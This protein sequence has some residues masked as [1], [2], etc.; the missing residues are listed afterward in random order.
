MKR[1]QRV[2][3]EIDRRPWGT[4]KRIAF[5]KHIMPTRVS[6]VLLVREVNEEYLSMIEQWLAENPALQPIEVK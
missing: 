3:A 1:L 4:K 2:Q 5:D 6:G